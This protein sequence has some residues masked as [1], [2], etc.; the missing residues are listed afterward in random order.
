VCSPVYW[1]WL[2]R[3][4]Y[5]CHHPYA[6]ENDENVNDPLISPIVS[7]LVSSNC[8]EKRR[9]R[10]SVPRSEIGAIA[11][12]IVT[13]AIVS[14]R[15]GARRS[16]PRLH[17]L[18][19]PVRPLSKAA[20]HKHPAAA[21]EIKNRPSTLAGKSWNRWTCIVCP[22][23]ERERYLFACV[24]FPSLSLSLFRSRRER[25]KDCA[26]AVIFAHARVNA[27]LNVTETK[28]ARQSGGAL[29]EAPSECTQAWSR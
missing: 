11:S 28:R 10:I 21:N 19:N 9:S 6:I 27:V 5:L 3:E 15:A 22:V 7:R 23:I 2:K 12:R 4:V 29:R 26:G 16:P 17:Q 20:H 1:R 24:L 13:I 25:C 14:D 8:A 18:R